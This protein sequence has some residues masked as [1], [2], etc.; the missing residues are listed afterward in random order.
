MNGPAEDRLFLRHWRT[1]L[2]VWLIPVPILAAILIGDFA[3]SAI[4]VRVLPY[5]VVAIF[6]YTIC[7]QIPPLGLWRRGEITYFQMFTLSIPMAVVG[8]GCLLVGVF[9]HALRS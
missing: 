1:F 9:V 4:A 2:P 7:V 5:L 8:I 3:S 6:V